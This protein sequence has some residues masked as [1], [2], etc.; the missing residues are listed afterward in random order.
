MCPNFIK[1]IILFIFQTVAGRAQQFPLEEVSEGIPDHPVH[2][3]VCCPAQ[4][5][6]DLP[7]P[8]QSDRPNKVRTSPE[9]PL[10]NP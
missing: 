5:S 10:C 6:P 3:R 8:V 7:S 1:D 2:C 9:G 4:S